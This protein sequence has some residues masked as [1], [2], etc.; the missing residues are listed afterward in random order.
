MGTGGCLDDDHPVH[1]SPDLH[2][3]KETKIDYFNSYNII[4]DYYIIVYALRSRIP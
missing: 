2:A 4:F 3:E 1:H